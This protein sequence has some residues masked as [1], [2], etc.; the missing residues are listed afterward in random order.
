MSE[1]VALR[2]LRGFIFDMD[3]V[4]YRGDAVLPGAPEFTAILKRAGIPYLYLTNNS[5]TPSDQVANRLER[6]GIPTDPEEVLTSAEATAAALA[7]RLSTGKVL[8]VGEAGIRQALRAAGFEL[9]EEHRDADAVV[10]GIDRQVTYDRLKE[11][12]LAIR[13]GARFIA[14]NT[15]RT[16]PTEV[17]LIPGAGAIVGALEIATDV[18]P[19]VIGKPSAEIFRQALERLGVDGAHVGAVG[20]RPETDIAGGHE[21]GLRTIAVLTGVGTADE[22]AALDPPPDWVFA[23]LSELQRA[24]FGD[25]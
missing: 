4:I 19:V 17:G 10:V 23:N 6:M 5:S 3:G 24:Y 12:A 9:T 14:T 8:V 15:D 16:L 25:R 22:F 21:A 11:A 18:S 2:S 7:S 20:D 1:G 13:R